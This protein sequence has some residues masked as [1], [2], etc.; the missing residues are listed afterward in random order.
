MSLTAALAHRSSF[1]IYARRDS[2]TQLVVA[3]ASRGVLD[4]RRGLADS[5]R[6]YAEAAES[7]NTKRARRA[8]WGVFERWC[9]SNDATA[10][11]AT[12]ETVI[13]FLTDQSTMGKAVAT[14]QRYT[15]SIS[16][17]HRL[18]SLDDPTASE[19]VKKIATGIRRKR[20]TI[21][22]QKKALTADLLVEVVRSFGNTPRDIRDRAILLLGLVGAMRRS[23]LCALD[24]DDILRV[25]DGMVITI[26]R[27]KTDQE[28]KGRAVAILRT[29]T[30]FCPVQAIEAWLTFSQ[31][32]RGPL[33]VGF[34]ARSERLR[35]TR[36][37]NQTVADIVKRAAN[38]IGLDAK[39]FAGHSL[40]AG[41]VTTARQEG[42][43]WGTIMEQT[44]HRRLET[45]KLYARY[46]PDLFQATRVR[47]IFSALGKKK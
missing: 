35:E 40:R 29:D 10:L 7:T 9:E 23:E 22:R 15:Y 1:P 3:P 24:V 13:G 28:A 36:L 12:P 42:F 18:A 11:P 17:A 33:F 46:T 8:D 19:I 16:A 39:Q 5:A 45:V 34:M 26:R 20:G 31:R 44:G 30:P 38:A 43:D 2:N 47:D 27:S 14:L 21:Q 4:R 6:E 41:Y 25:D 37:S 32:D